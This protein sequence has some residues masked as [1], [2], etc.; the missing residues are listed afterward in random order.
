[1]AWKELIQKRPTLYYTTLSLATFSSGSGKFVS[2]PLEIELGHEGEWLS[3][4]FS[5]YPDRFFAFVFILL[6]VFDVCEPFWCFQLVVSIGSLWLFS[7]IL[8]LIGS[9]LMWVWMLLRENSFLLYH[10]W[11]SVVHCVICD[12]IM[13]LTSLRERWVLVNIAENDWCLN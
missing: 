6:G 9:A 5:S 7:F 11:V 2:Q 4:S 3:Y 13:G 1:M 10:F 12:W 8:Q